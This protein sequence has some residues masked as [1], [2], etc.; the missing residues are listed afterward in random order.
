MRGA[1]LQGANLKMAFFMGV[2]LGHA[3]ISS[4]TKLEPNYF[5]G[6]NLEGVNLRG[7]D[8]SG[9]LALTWEDVGKALIDETTKLPPRVI[10]TRQSAKP[11]DAVSRRIP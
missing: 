2:D 9:C 8:L 10:E 6:V 5:G 4:D 7:I 11:E 1:F 3:S